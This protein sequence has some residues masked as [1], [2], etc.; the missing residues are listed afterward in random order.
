MVVLGRGVLVLGER[1]GA[2]RAGAA[3]GAADGARL[4]AK[5]VGAL[6]APRE[7]AALA[8]EL[9][10][11]DGGEGGGGVMLGFV[12]VHLVDGDGGVDDG[13][14]DGLLLDDGLDVLG[15][16]ELDGLRLWRGGCVESND[17]GRGEKGKKGR[18]EEEEG[19]GKEEKV[20]ERK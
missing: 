10:H 14:L 18:G 1:G 12:L 6:L 17:G 19:K 8:L 20:K 16:G 7:R 2:A 3:E 5:G 15:V 11:G 4:A 13:G 9:V